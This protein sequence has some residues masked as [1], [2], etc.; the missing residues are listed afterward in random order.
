MKRLFAIILAVAMICALLCACG[1]N[2]GSA[3]GKVTTTVNSKYDDGYASSYAKSAS[4]DGDKKVYEFTDE[5]Y[6]EYTNNH[7]NT[8]GKDLQKEIGALH[9]SSG[10]QKTPYGE[11]AYIN[12]E[13]KAA[14][15]G[16]HTDQYDEA[17]A[18]EESKIAAEYGFKY[19]Q[20]IKDPVDTIKVIY[21][22]AN[23]QDTVFGT[24]EFTAEK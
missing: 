17:T 21:C 14:I 3:N 18:K 13:K 8:L 16:V 6:K 22:D 12:E 2:S 9:E 10:D 5:Q 15:V 19:F 7:K 23:N 20:N 24:F 1:G 4:N 11:Y